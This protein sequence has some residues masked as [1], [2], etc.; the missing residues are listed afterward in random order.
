MAPL[1]SCRPQAKACFCQSYWR[2]C[3]AASVY[4]LACATTGIAFTIVY[5]SA[6]DIRHI[7]HWTGRSCQNAADN[8]MLAV[9]AVVLW[10]SLMLATQLQR[11][12]QV[13]L[14]W[15]SMLPS[16]PLC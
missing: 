16:L 11:P 4:A 8:P 9:N 2:L 1:V 10:Q 3:S 5:G 14:H 6:V 13:L 15:L 12:Q 7:S